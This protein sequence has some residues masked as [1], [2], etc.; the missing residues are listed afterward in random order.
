MFGQFVELR[1]VPQGALEMRN[2]AVVEFASDEPGQT[3]RLRALGC[4]ERMI[5]G[6]IRCAKRTRNNP[7][8]LSLRDLDA[9][10]ARLQ[11]L[12][13]KK[14]YAPVTKELVKELSQAERIARATAAVVNEDIP[15]LNACTDAERKQKSDDELRERMESVAGITNRRR[16]YQPQ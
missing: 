14:G 5:K 2:G 15:F 7:R 11:Q 9:E 1:G 10:I 12:L 4:P 16:T 8:K 6:V 3:R 13:V